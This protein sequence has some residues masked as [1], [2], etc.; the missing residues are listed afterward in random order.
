[1][2]ANRP[3]RRRANP[4]SVV[5]VTAHQLRLTDNHGTVQ[6]R[7]RAVARAVMAGTYQGRDGRSKPFAARHQ[8]LAWWLCNAANSLGEIHPRVMTLGRLADELGRDKDGVNRD[9]R[10]LEAAGIVWRRPIPGTRG[11]LYVY[12]IPGMIAPLKVVE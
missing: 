2:H 8:I 6:A 7:E 5:P 1:M 10:E 4:L 3:A 12:V 11:P 9:V